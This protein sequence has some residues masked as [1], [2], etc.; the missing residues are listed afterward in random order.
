MRGPPGERAPRRRRPSRSAPACGDQRRELGGVEEGAGHGAVP[1][2]GRSSSF[3]AT[4]SMPFSTRGDAGRLSNRGSPTPAA[5]SAT[6]TWRRSGSVTHRSS[7]RPRRQCSEHRRRSPISSRR[8]RARRWTPWSPSGRRILGA[9]LGRKLASVTNM[10]RARTALRSG[11]RTVKERE[12]VAA[13]N[14]AAGQRAAAPRRPGGGVQGGDRQARGGERARRSSRSWRSPS[15][16]GS[17]TSRWGSSSSAGPRGAREM[18]A[19]PRQPPP[20]SDSSRCRAPGRA[21][22]NAMKL[23]LMGLGERWSNARRGWRAG[24]RP[25]AKS[26]VWKASPRQMGLGSRDVALHVWMLVRV[27]PRSPCTPRAVCSGS[28]GPG[29]EA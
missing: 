25:C 10:N 14:A 1:S 12:D 22:T 2:R 24:S 3:A 4:P 8:P 7:S 21:H 23:H 28:S 18:M 5:S 15:R 20:C 6:P 17:R 27:R 13:A 11:S 29:D 26:D 9:F 19:F 16:L